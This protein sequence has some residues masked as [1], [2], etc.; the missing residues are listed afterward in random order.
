MNQFHELFPSL[1]L[2]EHTRKIGGDG[3]GVL[4]LDSSHLHTQVFGF[5]DDHHA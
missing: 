2:I 3:H 4:F 1:G 5:D